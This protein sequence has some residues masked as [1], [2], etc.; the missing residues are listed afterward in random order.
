MNAAYKWG[1]SHLQFFWSRAWLRPSHG[2]IVGQ[3]RAAGRWNRSAYQRSKPTNTTHVH[4]FHVI[5]QS[6]TTHVKLI[7]LG[8]QNSISPVTERQQFG[9]VYKSIGY[10]F[11]YDNL[12]YFWSVLNIQGLV[13]CSVIR[14]QVHTSFWHAHTQLM[15]KN[16]NS[17]QN[18]H[19]M[20]S[21]ALSIKSTESCDFVQRP[22]GSQQQYQHGHAAAQAV[23][24]EG[25]CHSIICPMA[26]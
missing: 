25:K 6:I 26:G 13:Q 11:P 21:L 10:F 2:P 5:N 9:Q 23:H 17:A 8:C 7:Q 24:M 4:S 19:Y 20:W 18:S 14:A 1:H 3:C 16:C 15:T 12:S 22:V